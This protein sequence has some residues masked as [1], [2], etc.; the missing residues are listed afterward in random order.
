MTTLKERWEAWTAPESLEDCV[1]LFIEILEIRET[2]DSGTEFSPN[3][4][5]SCRVWDTHRM[6]KLID[7]MK[8]L[9]KSREFNSN[10]NT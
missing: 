8:D 3:Q 10:T 1:K 9:T 7:K 4:I 2:S 6:H 5:S